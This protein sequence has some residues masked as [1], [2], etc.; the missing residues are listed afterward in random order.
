MTIFLILLLSY[1]VFKAKQ[2]EILNIIN[3]FLDKRTKQ[4]FI[5]LK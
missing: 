4:K 5:N 3:K 1:A 2:D